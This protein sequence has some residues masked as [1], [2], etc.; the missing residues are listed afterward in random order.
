MVFFM[1]HRHQLLESVVPVLLLQWRLDYLPAQLTWSRL[2]LD[3]EFYLLS[4]SFF[5]RAKLSV[6]PE[7][8]LL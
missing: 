1:V 5:Q 7:D 6:R 4:G 3:L 2:A 8:A